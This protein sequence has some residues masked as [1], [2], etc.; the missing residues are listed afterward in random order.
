MIS[1]DGL[2]AAVLDEGRKAGSAGGLLQTPKKPAS[3]YGGVGAGGKIVG[4]EG[5]S[6]TVGGPGGAETARSTGAEKKQKMN[7][8]IGRKSESKG[9]EAAD[10]RQKQKQFLAGVGQFFIQ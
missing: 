5:G 7:C 4:G 3:G 2:R 1:A 6:G 9:P 10:S 8:W